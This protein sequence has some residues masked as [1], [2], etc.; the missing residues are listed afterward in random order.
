MVMANL[1]QHGQACISSSLLKGAPF[2]LGQH[3]RDRRLPVERA[4]FIQDPP[5][6]FLLDHFNTFDVTCGMR[7]PGTYSVFCSWSHIRIVGCG[8]DFS[9]PDSEVPLQHVEEA[10]EDPLTLLMCLLNFRSE[11]TVTPRYLVLLTFS[12]GVLLIR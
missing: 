4:I 7:V 9:V 11:D 2:E 5:G 1:V 3:V 6:S 8:L 12:S 10:S